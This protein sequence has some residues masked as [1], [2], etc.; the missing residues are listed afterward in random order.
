MTLSNDA[1]AETLLKQIGLNGRVARDIVGRFYGEISASL[2]AGNFVGLRGSN[3]FS[4]GE[5]PQR[6]DRDS[7][8]C[9]LIPVDARQ[10]ASSG[11]GPELRAKADGT[12]RR[13]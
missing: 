6:L 12:P 3:R 5:L 8:T 10:M 4:A 11:P 2:E 1:L 7:P 9:E 13:S